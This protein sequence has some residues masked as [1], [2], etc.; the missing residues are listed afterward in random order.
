MPIYTDYLAAAVLYNIQI[1]PESLICGLII[2]AIVLANQNLLVLAVGTGA[3]Q[4][5]TSTV[6]R[7]IMNYMP[8]GA[9]VTSS[10]NMCA[11]GYVGK[12]WARLLRG[13]SAPELLWHPKAPSIYTATLGFLAGWG[14][15]LRQ[16]YK[17]EISAG[18]ISGSTMLATAITMGLILLLALVYR[19]F[20]GC[21]TI[22]GAMGGILLGLSMGY[23]GAIALGYATNRRATNIWGMP[24]LR[25]RIN[26]GSALYVCE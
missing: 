24:L 9:V 12:S 3:A 2:L 13:T 10:N 22:I 15:A 7:L 6:G 19:I 26:D 23:F 5:L 21:E 16:L 1:L 20:S 14:F 8:D 11:T 25:D 4:M 17:E 18:V